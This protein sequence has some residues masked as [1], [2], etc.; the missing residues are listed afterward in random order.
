MTAAT[1]TDA[2]EPVR[3]RLRRDAEDEAARLRAAAHAQAA[4]I[5]AQ[6]QREATATLAAA[7]A[8]AAATA[9]PLTTAELRQARD[10]ARSAVLTAQRGACDEL[11]SRVCSAV[12]ALPAQPGYEQ[13][14]HRITVLARQAAG[15]DAELTAPAAG[16]VIACRPGVVV[17]CSLGRLADLAATELGPAI[18]ELWAP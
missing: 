7:A 1:M 15:P 13:L 10:A 17:D 9:D 16:G 3:Q 2:L 8:Q 4:A 6:A 18:T 11:R 5:V 12:A 14:L